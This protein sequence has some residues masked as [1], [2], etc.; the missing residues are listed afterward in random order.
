[1]VAGLTHHCTPERLRTISK[2]IPKV[3]I[4]TGDE[5]H[6]VL[7]RNSF[8]LKAA[9][10]EAEFVQWEQTGHGIHVQKMKEFNALIERACEEGRK[11]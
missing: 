9:M 6:L 8:K 10:P 1:M 11:A 2:S 7:P 4:V 3:V 5:D